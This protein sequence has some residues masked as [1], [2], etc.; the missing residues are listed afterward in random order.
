MI[1]L[2]K[3]ALIQPS[4]NEFLIIQPMSRKTNHDNNNNDNNNNN[5]KTGDNNDNTIFTSF[6][7]FYNDS[8]G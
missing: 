5:N 2:P 3:F 7:K 8:A 1:V 6:T 4:W